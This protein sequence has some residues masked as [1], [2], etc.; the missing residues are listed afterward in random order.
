MMSVLASATQGEHHNELLFEP[1]WFGLIA[2]GVMMG[3][4]ALLWSFRNTL[5]LDPHGG[6]GTDSGSAN[7]DSGRGS[8]L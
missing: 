1:V 3:L 2:F 4:L 8:H 5:T 6:K 7:P